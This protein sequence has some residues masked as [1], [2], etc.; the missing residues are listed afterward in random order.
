MEFEVRSELDFPQLLALNRLS[1]KTY[2]K[3]ISRCSRGIGGLLGSVLILSNILLMQSEGF[4][5]GVVPGF[6]LGGV[7]LAVCFFYHYVNA[8]GSSRQIIKKARQ[9]TVRMDEAGFTEESEMATIH[10]KY[11]VFYALY[12]YSGYFFLFLDKKHAYI[13]PKAA[14]V[15]GDPAVF[16]QFIEEKSGIMMKTI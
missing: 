11:S 14:F 15:R 4:Y 13:L 5:I 8:W 2:R 7:F 12:T 10:H 6:L 1:G 3:W 16:P 9:S